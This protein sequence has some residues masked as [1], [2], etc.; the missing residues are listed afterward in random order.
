MSGNIQKIYYRLEVY[1]NYVDFPIGTAN[2]DDFEIEKLLYNPNIRIR[3]FSFILIS[4]IKEYN[5]GYES[6]PLIAIY[7]KNTWKVY[8]RIERHYFRTERHWFDGGLF[9]KTFF[10]DRHQMM[11]I[12]GTV[13]KIPCNTQEEI[14]NKFNVISKILNEKSKIENKTLVRKNNKFM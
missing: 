14:I 1:N 11:D 4:R 9:V 10:R 5:D 3:D 7:N 12:N 8:S 6:K 13:K 2:I